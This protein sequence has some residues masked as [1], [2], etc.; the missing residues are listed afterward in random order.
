MKL[1]NQTKEYNDIVHWSEG[2]DSFIIE[3]MIRFA[4]VLPE[5]FTTSNISSF[6]RQLNLYGFKKL[7]TK[8]EITEFQHPL[9]KRGNFSDILKIKKV[10]KKSTGKCLKSEL[11]ELKK[12]YSS[13]QED[14]DALK[15]SMQEMANKNKDLSNFNEG[16]FERLN[17]E[18][19]D[20]KNDLKHLLLLLFSTIKQNKDA[21]I[22]MIKTL[23]FNTKILSKV[24]KN[25]LQTSDNFNKLLPLIIDKITE[26]KDTR[27]NFIRKLVNLF[28]FDNKED[29]KLKRDLILYYKGRLIKNKLDIDQLL[30][31]EKPSQIRKGK[32]SSQEFEHDAIEGVKGSKHLWESE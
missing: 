10:V 24:E 9:F 14:F 4:M 19:E 31:K 11:K 13:L 25:I 1:N 26:D 12:N 15:K 17:Q 29:K 18:R 27:N 21:F 5:F 2:K 6:I 23:F 8:K 30:Q 28:Y 7:K 32:L 20:Y 3:D 22:K 16:I